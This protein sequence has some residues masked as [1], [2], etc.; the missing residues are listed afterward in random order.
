[1]ER[2]PE[3]GEVE[4][5][6]VPDSR[7]ADGRSVAVRGSRRAAGH[8]ATGRIG[9]ACLAAC[10]A[11]AGCAHRAAAPAGSAA[12]PAGSAA[13]P[14]LPTA[15][16]GA[17]D[18]AAA[19]AAASR[20]RFVDVAAEAGLSRVLLAGRSEKPHLLESAGSGVAF[21]DYD[22]DGRLDVFLPNAWRLEG[23]RIV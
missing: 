8:V 10:L 13:S 3:A 9:A 5:R 7:S 4:P 12:T 20:F 19:P 17:A 22:R 18:S 11:L 21:L 14:S 23:E 15:A 2:P 16:I 1:L 6:F